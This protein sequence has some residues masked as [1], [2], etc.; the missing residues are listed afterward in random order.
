M[1]QKIL[2]TPAVME[3]SNDEGEGEKAVYT[4]IR[5]FSRGD[6]GKI[7]QCDKEAN[8]RDL[9]AGSGRILARYESPKGDFYIISY[10]GTDQPPTVLFCREY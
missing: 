2:F 10:P 6:W 1:K 4:A 3:M 5:R 7:P 8:D 9:K